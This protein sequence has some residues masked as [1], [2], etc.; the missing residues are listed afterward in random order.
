MNSEIRI[1]R[2]IDLIVAFAR[3]EETI[4]RIQLKLQTLVDKLERQ[5]KRLPGI[6]AVRLSDLRIEPDKRRR[7]RP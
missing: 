6:C 3:L 5:A 7:T 4:A 2:K 1:E